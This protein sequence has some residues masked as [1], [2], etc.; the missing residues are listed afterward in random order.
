MQGRQRK[1]DRSAH[2]SSVFRETRN[3]LPLDANFLKTLWRTSRHEGLTLYI[4]ETE[5][6]P[7][8]AELK[9][10][11]ELTEN[12][13]AIKKSLEMTLPATETCSR[14]WQVVKTCKRRRTRGEFFAVKVGIL[15][16]C[17]R[18]QPGD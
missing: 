5:E 18:S 15:W 12:T 3:H 10:L 17:H 7:I 4:E 1:Q 6:A 16:I 13:E 8:L 9:S 11:E 2:I 14:L